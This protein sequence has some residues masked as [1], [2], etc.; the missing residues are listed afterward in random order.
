MTTQSNFTDIDRHYTGSGS[1]LERI[2]T[3][4]RVAGKDLNALQVDDLAPVDEFHSRGRE[5]TLELARLAQGKITPATKVIDVGCGLGGT[6][7]HL[8]HA[9][10][11]HVTGVDLTSEFVH[12]GQRLTELVGLQDRVTLYQGS[13]LDLPFAAGT[14][15]VAWTEHV[16][17]NIQDKDGFYAQIH[18]VLTPGGSVFFH[19]IFRGSSQES[20]DYPLPWAEHADLSYLAT[21]EEARSAM[22]M[23]GLH[24]SQWIVKDEETLAGMTKLSEIIM[25]DAPPPLG[26]HLLLGVTGKEKIRNYVKNL[27][28]NRI[29]VVMGVAE[30]IHA[31]L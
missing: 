26:L 20:P 11:C 4:L 10:N 12:V 31:R 14:F 30:K 2:E 29:T 6:A 5:S 22:E 16:Q 19:D 1:L 13:A 7:R 28:S 18:R 24:V 15:D 27:S 21:A 17:M 23:A 9:Y 3:A 25:S 8:T